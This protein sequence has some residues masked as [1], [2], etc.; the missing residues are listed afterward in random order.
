[1]REKLSSLESQK[2]DLEEEIRRLISNHK[3]EIDSKE[4]L[5][6]ATRLQL[7]GLQEENDKLSSRFEELMT[8]V[9]QKDSQTEIEVN[10]LKHKIILLQAE[11]SV[12]NVS[13][14]NVRE[15]QEE[16]FFLLLL[17]INK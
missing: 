5:I 2:V 11:L 9:L 1:M 12:E 13:T 8:Q 3:F 4:R 10:N 17:K 7:M 6:E 16:V 15:L 14:Q